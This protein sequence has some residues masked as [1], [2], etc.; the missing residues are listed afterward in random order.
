[1]A[2]VKINSIIPCKLNNKLKRQNKRAEHSQE[3]ATPFTLMLTSKKAILLSFIFLNFDYFFPPKIK[4]KNKRSI[5][6]SQ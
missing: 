1:M 5:V 3:L 2:I 6:E 4:S